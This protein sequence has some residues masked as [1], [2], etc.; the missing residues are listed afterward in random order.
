MNQKTS[1]LWV[2][3]TV[4]LVPKLI[5]RE[6]RKVE[7]ALQMQSCEG[8]LVE[9]VVPFCPVPPHTR[10]FRREIAYVPFL[11]LA[12]GGDPALRRERIDPDVCESDRGQ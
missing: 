9:G 11:F 6:R 12:L 4:V 5:S 7:A 1:E 8:N 10:Q 2:I 3:P